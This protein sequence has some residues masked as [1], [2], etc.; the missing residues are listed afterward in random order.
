MCVKIYFKCRDIF[1]DFE[2]A[3]TVELY[4]SFHFSPPRRFISNKPDQTWLFCDMR[5]SVRISCPPNGT[6]EFADTVTMKMS[7]EAHR[8]PCPLPCQGPVTPMFFCEQ[9]STCIELSKLIINCIR[10][11]LW[12]IFTHPFLNFSGVLAKPTL[13]LGNAW[14][15][16]YTK[17]TVRYNYLY[18]T[19]TK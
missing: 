5:R 7:V 12:D 18:T 6:R 11:K 16:H 9:R 13:K 10:V 8:F 14:M 4:Q 3:Q 19:T 2:L 17:N 1:C 15:G